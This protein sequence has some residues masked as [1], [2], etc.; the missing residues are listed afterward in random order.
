MAPKLYCYIDETGQDTLGELFIVSVVV[1]DEEKERLIQICEA[2]EQKTGKGRVKW[3][4]TAY[5][6]RVAYIQ[7]LLANSIF[8][9]KL[10]FAT[11]HNTK[12]YAYLTVQTI[13]QAL[14]N[15]EETNYKATIFID[16]LPRTQERFVGHQLRQFGVRT[17]KVRGVKK[18]E[19]D[20]LI[21]LADAVCGFVRAAM[22]G[23]KNNE[24]VV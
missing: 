7:E 19:N 17:K 2:I 12:E 16:G 24:A 14:E 3:I 21:R 11:Y 6:R 5:K 20:A 13:A 18:D 4:K 10:N 23:Q 1:S 22:E 9:G 8:R 15:V